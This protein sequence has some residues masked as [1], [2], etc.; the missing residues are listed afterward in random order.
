MDDSPDEEDFV[1]APIEPEEAQRDG[2]FE[3][4]LDGFIF[5]AWKPV[6]LLSAREELALKGELLRNSLIP[7]S[8]CS[9]SCLSDFSQKK[10]YHVCRVMDSDTKE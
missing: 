7:R 10:L 2:P 5:K 4:N 9:L 8:H 3:L 1:D 6:P